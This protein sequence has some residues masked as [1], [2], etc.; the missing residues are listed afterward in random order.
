MQPAVITKKI[1]KYFRA[2]YIKALRRP[3]LVQEILGG[4]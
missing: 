2:I 3:R 1:R 4:R